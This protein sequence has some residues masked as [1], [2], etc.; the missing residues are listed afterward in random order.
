MK[1]FSRRAFI[2]AFAFI[3][4]AAIGFGS[5]QNVNGSF[6]N[7]RNAI[8]KATDRLVATQNN[9]GG[10]E[11]NN[12][13]TNPNETSPFNTLGVTAQG[14]LDAYKL[15]ANSGYLTTAIKSYNGL[16]TRSVSS[17]PSTH[18]MRG[19]D[20][21]FLV[22]LSEVTGNS[23]YADFSRTRW[24]SA[25]VEFGSGSATGFA[26]YVRDIRKGQNLPVLISWDIDL[27]I[28][29]ML[30]LDRY[31]PGQG[32]S[33]QADS[34][35]EV[36]Y[37]SLFVVPK[38]F[39][40]TN[41]GQSE[42]WLAFTGAVDAF[43]STSVHTSETNVLLTTLLAS[44]AGNGHFIGVGDGSD[45]QTTAYA[46]P[47]LLKAGG[48]NTAVNNAVNYLMSFQQVNGGWLDN[49][50]TEYTEITSEAA[51]AIF[52]FLGG[53]FCTIQDA[54]NA[55]TNGDTINVA[56]STYVLSGRLTISK[57]LT[58][59]GENES[60]TIIDAR[61]NGT[62]Y[63]ILISAS[64]VTLSNFTIKPPLGPGA[65]GTSTG[66]GF[67]IHVSNTP[68]IL[69]N[70]TIT[71]VT[72]KNGNRSGV[73]INGTDHAV[74]SYVTTQNA[75]YGNGINITGV[76]GAN[77]S[78]ITT[79]GN[80]WGGIAVYVSIPSQANRGS[81]NITIDATTC[82]IPEANKIYAQNESGLVN[83]NVTVT[84][85]DYTAKNSASA[86][87]GYTWYQDNLTNAV[88][89]SNLINTSSSGSYII[90]LSSGTL[91]VGSGMNIQS[92]I[93]AASAGG[94]VHV[95]A[96][97]FS[98]QLTIAKNLHL[99]GAGIGSSIIQA[100]G[101]IPSSSNPASTIVMISGS[102]VSAEF[103]GFT[104]TG[105]GPTGC[106]SILGG[107]FVRNGAT[108][109]I[110][111]NRI[112]DI[113]DLTF[114]GC[115]N[116]QGI[117]VGRQ[118]W[119]TIGTATI[120]NN[121]I[122]GYQ[123][124]GIVVDNTGSS[125]IITNNT[126]TG[127]GTT[128]IIAQNGIQI[129]RGATAILS[130]NTITGNSYNGTGDPSSTW[131]SA[132]ILLYQS[133]AVTM[134]GGNT[135]TGNDQ[136]LDKTGASGLLTLGAETF[137]ASTAPAG[138]GFDIYNDD[139]LAINAANVT[140]LG[141]TNG[142]AIEDRVYHKL[143]D[144][145]KG[146]VTWIDNNVYVTTSS[147][148]IQR[149][150]D[151]VSSG[152][153]VNV[154]AGT[155]NESITI[156]KLVDV[157]GSGI[158]STILTK[159]VLVNA[160]TGTGRA[161]LRN[162]SVLT[163][164]SPYKIDT[165]Y[166]IFID[167]SGG[168]TGP[169]T[170]DSVKAKIYPSLPTVYGA[171]LLISP[172]N[173][174]INDVVISH[175]MF[176]SSYSHGVYIKNA[177]ATTGNVSALQISNSSFNYDDRKII[178][179]GRSFSGY[180]LYI[181]APAAS[182]TL[183]VNGMTVTNSTF[184]G[185]YRKGLYIE[186]LKNA[187]FSGVTVTGNG[188]EGLDLNLKYG[189]YSN[190]SFDKCT[191]TNNSANGITLNNGIKPDIHSKGRD[192][193]PYNT[194]PASL[195][196]VNITSS[197]IGYAGFG[198]NIT[199][200]PVLTASSIQT[201]IL[202]YMNS[203][204]VN[205]YGNWWRTTDTTVISSRITGTVT[206]SPWWDGNYIGVAHPWTWSANRDLLTTI[207]TLSHG[208]TLNFMGSYSGRLDILK[209]VVVKF[210][211][212][213]TLDS[214]TVTSGDLVLSS[215]VTISGNLN[216]SNGNIV[217]RDSNR[218]VLDTSAANP[219]ETQSGAIIGT[220]EV[221]PRNVGTGSLGMVGLTIKAGN[222]NL[223]K[224]GVTR[225]SGDNAAVTISNK[226]GIATTWSIQADH[227]PTSGRNVVFSWLPE[228][229]NNVD[230]TQ[231][232]VYRN[233][234][235]G[236][237]LYAGPFS[238]SGIPRQVTVNT[239]GFSSWTIGSIPKPP[240]VAPVVETALNPRSITF[241]PVKIG[242]WK[243]TIVTVTNVGNDILQVTGIT[244]TKSYFG[245]RP[246]VLS[247]PPGQT[248]NDTIRFIPDSIG[249]R[250]AL[251]Q[252]VS[253]AVTSP[254]TILVTGVGVGTPGLTLNSRNIAFTVKIGQWKDTTVTI[255]N[256]GNDTLKIASITSTKSYFSVRPTSL[257]I[258][259][260]QTM[261]D[262]IRFVSDSN[263]VRNALIRFVSNAVTSPDTIVV[264]GFG[265]GTP[266][267]SLN[268]RFIAFPIVKI[269]QWKDTV[270]SVTN[271]TNICFD[272]LKITNITSTKSCFIVHPTIL[273]IPPGQTM[274]DTIRFTSDSLGVR[275]ALIEYISNAVT[276]LNTIVVTGNGTTSGIV[277]VGP[278][279][280]ESYALFQN[281]PN[282]FNPTTSITYSI[283]QGEKQHTVAIRIYDL[284]GR[285]V[286][287]LV[288]EMKPVGTYTVMWDAASIPSGIYFYRMQSDNFVMTKKLVLIR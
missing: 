262:T 43:T 151:A 259:P 102:S 251:I 105:P 211:T 176:D 121:I 143:D 38:D 36:V 195:S 13:N 171:G 192:D 61:A 282:P 165:R 47:A 272:T 69:S 21:S 130:G 235:S 187:S 88:A 152:S 232:V 23:V 257:T 177:T 93:D 140:F 33:R 26:Q 76:H 169:V 48:N 101:T 115:Q 74:V 245:V 109:N 108:A 277:Q 164:D 283:P 216:L 201:G 224:V 180:G 106:G 219:T 208:D 276:S 242:R 117:W 62:D 92:T 56:S 231:I 237:Q 273:I 131:G 116:G 67:A 186:S 241:P 120:N 284:L 267:L 193:A 199:N 243:D 129:S 141:A 258:P 256:I 170:I 182:P 63:G 203:G 265:L 158:G 200:S 51:H 254:D 249:V 25:K 41:M 75:A 82:S 8:V 3:T 5:Q 57:S 204:S 210:T 103:T 197:V 54:I 64:N 229:D 80:A 40:A 10:W 161:K 30:A 42:Y 32:Y 122:V 100:P 166:A 228:F 194:N 274:I 280:P 24:N 163:T 172:E 123:K 71:H 213:P 11:W 81:D 178:A 278:E 45:V 181:L 260:G 253:N 234:G 138:I 28:Q 227:Q 225:T 198:N 39:D 149:G 127:V 125:A 60:T 97:T 196:N 112:Q 58:L 12:P 52:K 221:A 2:C 90:Q 77:I 217:T 275:S 110:H 288:N 46:I 285:E 31:Y 209:N 119:S 37:T 65:L 142:F 145:T 114:S 70:V 175:C 183:I 202:N 50:G 98:E 191:F 132:G 85:Y 139:N 96:G 233:D 226:A 212:P 137:G 159:S 286:A 147:G 223:E 1:S 263:E 22:E 146:L 126:I 287:T 189:S 55:S 113:R 6:I 270:V 104:V 155:Y 94:T 173:N 49:V 133:G 238:I 168:N 218:I 185:N 15:T 135:A 222:D 207:D 59:L 244:S 99:I 18:K 19:P 154:A 17:D 9:D 246:V 35:A 144:A 7:Q 134:F 20:I 252:Y 66:G 247:I 214:V 27:Y 84:G 150:I 89:Y 281:Y 118:A 240:P 34:M 4:P 188:E 53:V 87:S 162:L 190:I 261:N 220:V 86:L 271:I 136:N 95:L 184:N 68:S 250:N 157:N 73:D 255:T 230:T 111:D 78:H 128:T 14:V 16:L 268:P 156:N 269:G 148:S 279:M 174:T 179:E 160:G 91:Y 29:G 248:R 264:T 167:G 239:T 153:T 79:G 205:C 72:V 107:I 83:T 215:T 266:K 206:Y 236:W 44:Q 124:G